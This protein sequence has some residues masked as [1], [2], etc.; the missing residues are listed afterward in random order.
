VQRPL[1]CWIK[2]FSREYFSENSLTQSGDVRDLAILRLTRVHASI[3][4]GRSQ[5]FDRCQIDE[6]KLDFLSL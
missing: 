1:P 4:P 6:I 5:P 3:A 2:A